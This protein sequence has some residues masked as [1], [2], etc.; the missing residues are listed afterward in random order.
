MNKT[1]SPSLWSG[2]CVYFDARQ[3]RALTGTLVVQKEGKKT[4]LEFVEISMKIGEKNLSYPT[5]KSGEFYI[6]NSLSTDSNTEA[7]ASQDNQSCK[8]IGKLR[9]SGGNSILPG[10]YRA[11]VDYEDGKCEF[12]ITF[13]DTKEAITDLGEIQCVVSQASMSTPSAQ[14]PAGSND[15]NAQRLN[16]LP[17]K[18]RQRKT[19]LFA[20]PDAD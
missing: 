6:E 10:I 12:S 8:A 11:T 2:S 16:P 3:V 9:K 18:N 13:P 20:F 1:I 14:V 7:A 4:P 19:V 17:R 15:Q 5:G